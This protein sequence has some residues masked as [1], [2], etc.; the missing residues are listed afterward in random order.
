MTLTH[1]GQP[2]K[3]WRLQEYEGSSRRVGKLLEL[4]GK[5]ADSPS[6]GQPAHAPSARTAYQRAMGSR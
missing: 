2:L 5:E 3:P 1:T 4:Q 6:A